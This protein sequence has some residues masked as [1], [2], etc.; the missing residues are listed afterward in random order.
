V[1]INASDP[2]TTT[3]NSTGATSTSPNLRAQNSSATAVKT[4]IDTWYVFGDI[5]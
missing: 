1:V 5:I 3:I 2:T 4:D